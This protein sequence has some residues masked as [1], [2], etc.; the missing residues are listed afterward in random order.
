M[1]CLFHAYSTTTLISTTGCRFVS[2]R[3]TSFWGFSTPSSS[4]SWT[5]TTTSFGH[6]SFNFE[7]SSYLSRFRVQCYSSRRSNG[8]RSRATQ[9]SDPKA[10]ME[11]E[12]STFFVARKG[13]IV[14]V[15]KNLSDCQAQVGSSVITLLLLQSFFLFAGF[16]II[17]YIICLFM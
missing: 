6:A 2:R 17:F 9:K 12:K 4:S 8:I 13:D 3:T 11:Q 1:N 10:D 14:G 7:S 16:I 5:K 15:Y